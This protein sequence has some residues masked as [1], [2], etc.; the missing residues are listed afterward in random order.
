[1]N[2]LP[3]SGVGATSLQLFERRLDKFWRDAPI[4]YNY[5]DTDITPRNT[6]DISMSDE[7][8]DLTVRGLTA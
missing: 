8:P 2:N 4:R 6:L 7:D 3:S 1:M 5:R